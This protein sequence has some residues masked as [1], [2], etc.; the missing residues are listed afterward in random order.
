MAEPQKVVHIL[1]PRA[2]ENAAEHSVTK[3]SATSTCPSLVDNADVA[4]VQCTGDDAGDENEVDTTEE[5]QELVSN[6]RVQDHLSKALLLLEQQCNVTRAMVITKL[7]SHVTPIDAYKFCGAHFV[8]PFE[9]TVALQSY[10]IGCS[11]GKIKSSEKGLHSTEFS[12]DL[13]I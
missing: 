3:D 11:T 5:V 4:Q 12:L 9:V 13:L 10:F 6:A 2:P 1:H 7:L 8:R